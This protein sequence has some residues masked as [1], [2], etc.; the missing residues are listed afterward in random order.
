M[1]AD[2]NILLNMFRDN[3]VVE[4]GECIFPV[5]ASS[6]LN[7]F[8]LY[9]DNSYAIHQVIG[10]VNTHLVGSSAGTT[11]AMHVHSHVR[12]DPDY[13]VSLHTRKQFTMCQ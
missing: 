2:Y 3:K 6:L 10:L 13:S 8:L 5:L 4:T 7:M 12:C 11:S 1:I 9:C